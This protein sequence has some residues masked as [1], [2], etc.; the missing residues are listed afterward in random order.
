MFSS[1]FSRCALAALLVVGYRG[2]AG[3]RAMPSPAPSASPLTEIGCVTTSDRRSEPIWQTSRPTFII[4]RART[5][6]Q[7][8][9]TIAVTL[10]DVPGV[11]LFPYGSS[12]AQVDY[13]IRGATSTQTLVLIDGVPVADRASGTPIFGY[14]NVGRRFVVDVSTR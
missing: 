5:E 14:P 9:R 11:H 2:V 8:A 12:G 10:Q 3:A 1:L 13:G 7:G 4:D 6:N